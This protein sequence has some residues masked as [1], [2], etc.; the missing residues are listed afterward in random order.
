M[1]S[2]NT[3]LFLNHIIKL[4]KRIL[5]NSWHLFSKQISDIPN[6]HVPQLWTILWCFTKQNIQFQ[7]FSNQKKIEKKKKQIWHGR[8]R[9]R[10]RKK[11]VKKGNEEYPQNI[12][13]TA[14]AA[15]TAKCGCCQRQWLA[16]HHGGI[17]LLLGGCSC[18]FPHTPSPIPALKKRCQKINNLFFGAS[19]SFPCFFVHSSSF[20]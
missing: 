2:S 16:Q 18:C 19:F 20:F 8:R 1:T 12:S 5:Y 4:R 6:I 13:L 11:S 15:T 17:F 14:A 3:V 7:K 10:R 9:R